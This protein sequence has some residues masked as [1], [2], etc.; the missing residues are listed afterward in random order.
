MPVDELARTYSAWLDDMGPM[1]PG[2][3]GWKRREAYDV[4]ARA[5]VADSIEI[6]VAL[7]VSETSGLVVRVRGSVTNRSTR[8]LRDVTFVLWDSQGQPV[9]WG[10]TEKQVDLIEF[11]PLAPGETLPFADD[12]VSTR[13]PA[14]GR[15]LRFR[16]VDVLLP[17]SIPRLPT[18]GDP[19]R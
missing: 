9:I 4:I 18:L 12:F 7:E 13:P 10:G 16:V 11:D 2:V 5:A 6:D 17:N 15:A 1:W 8:M 3:R 14:N 19:I